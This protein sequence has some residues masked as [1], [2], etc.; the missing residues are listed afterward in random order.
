MHEIYQK[1][2]NICFSFA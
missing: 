2:V 1:T